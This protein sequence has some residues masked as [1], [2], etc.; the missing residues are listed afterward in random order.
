MPFLTR[1]NGLSISKSAAEAAHAEEGAPDL[2][3]MPEWSLADL[4]TAPDA[5]QV[6]RDIEAAASAAQRM[7]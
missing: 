1:F 3:S 6:A 4:Y 5:P 2:G 7:K